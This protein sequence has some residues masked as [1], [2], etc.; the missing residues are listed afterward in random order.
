MRSARVC[1]GSCSTSRLSASRATSGCCGR[2]SSSPSSA[3][4]SRGSR[5][6]SRSGSSRGSPAAVGLTGPH[7]RS[8]RSSRARSSA[9]RSSMRRTAGRSSCGPRSPSRSSA[10]ILLAGAL[11]GHPPLALIYGANA[12][13]AFV[14]AIDDPARSG[15]DT[16]AGGHRADPVRAHPEPGPVADREHRRPGRRRRADRPVRLRPRIRARPRD[17]RR[18]VPRGLLDAPDAARE[19]SGLGGGVGGGQGGLRLRD[20]RS[21]DLVDVRDRPD[22]DDLRDAGGALPRARRSRSST[23]A[24]PWSA[25]CSRRPSVGAL[26]GAL[27]GGWVSQRPTPGRC[28]DLGGG[29]VGRCDRRVRPRRLA[30]VAGRSGSSR[31]RAPPTWSARSS[32]RRSRR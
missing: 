10:G 15:D 3:T 18:V 31:S 14:G 32:A 16:A 26:V 1:G 7:G 23:A 13:T 4:S 29:G 21:A 11:A 8:W 25:C 28:R 5:S 27:S 6:T 24:P 17:V 22:R 12:L 19:R 9:R 20:G 2:G 30:P